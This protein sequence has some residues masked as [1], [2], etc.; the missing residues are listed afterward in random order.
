MVGI[1]ENRKDPGALIT[2]F[3]FQSMFKAPGDSA[4]RKD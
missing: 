2:A 4:N 1:P 3:L